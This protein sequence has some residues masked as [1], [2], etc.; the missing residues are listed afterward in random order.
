MKPT[1]K[2]RDF[3]TAIA[4]M[5]GIDLPEE[6]TKESYHDFIDENI[7]EFHKVQ[8]EIRYKDK[9]KIRFEHSYTVSDGYNGD[10]KLNINPENL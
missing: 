8:N 6:Y 7:D 1:E 3:A 9:S 5:L 10:T 4:E 2:Q